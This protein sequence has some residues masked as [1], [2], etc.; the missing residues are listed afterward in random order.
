MFSSSF[1][2][3]ITIFL[4]SFCPRACFPTF[5]LE[6]A[7]N[8]SSLAF[9]PSLHFARAH[10]NLLLKALSHHLLLAIQVSCPVSFGIINPS[11]QLFI[12]ME[13]KAHTFF[14]LLISFR[15]MVLNLLVSS[16][17]HHSFSYN[18]DLCHEN[19]EETRNKAATVWCDTWTERR[20]LYREV[21][22]LGKL[23]KVNVHEL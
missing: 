13:T 17:T 20:G 9:C 10:L 2:T 7:G 15:N 5:R 4:N 8:A 11:L 22:E 6:N 16:Q 19:T 14:F 3:F 18:E 12:N 21:W 1:I 23:R